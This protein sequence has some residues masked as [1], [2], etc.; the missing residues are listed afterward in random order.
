MAFSA[1]C[2]A[3]Y[4]GTARAAGPPPIRF[5]APLSGG[6]LVGLNVIENGIVCR[7]RLQ[8]SGLHHSTVPRFGCLS[9]RAPARQY[10]VFV[11]GGTPPG[12]R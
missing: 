12:Q 9:L 5:G 2:G 7:M 11:D 8:T 10:I 6:A 3:A 1:A 4:V